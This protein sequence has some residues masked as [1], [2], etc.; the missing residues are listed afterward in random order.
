MLTRCKCCSRFCNNKNLDDM[1]RCRACQPET[2][3][4]ETEKEKEDD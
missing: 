4:Q 3:K 2:D 1:G